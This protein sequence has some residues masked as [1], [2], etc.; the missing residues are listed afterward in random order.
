[1]QSVSLIGMTAIWV[2]GA[3]GLSGRG[4]ARELVDRG[5]DV[6]LVGR[7]QDKLASVSL[8][9]GGSVRTRVVVRSGRVDHAAS[10]REARRRRERS[11][12]IQRD[13]LAS[14][15]G[16]PC[17][18]S[19]LSG[20]GQ[21]ARAGAA[22]ARTGRRGPAAGRHAG[23]GSRFWGAGHRGARDRAAKWPPSTSA[24]HGRRRT[25]RAG[26]GIV[27]ACQRRR[28]NCLRRQ[29]ISGRT[30]GALPAWRTPRT[31]PDPGCAS[32]RGTGGTY[33]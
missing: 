32:A 26:A 7:D 14:C 19:A 5:A 23:H 1:M 27:G 6:V 18:R 3:T 30:T 22:I 24:R 2:F 16:L 29:T 25:S 10:R 9:V 21:R 20:P 4:V 12:P 8:S 31:D 28:R 11:R 15:P 33:R 13:Q 17:G